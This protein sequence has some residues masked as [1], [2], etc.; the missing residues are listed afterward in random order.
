MF[1]IDLHYIKALSEVEKF[2]PEHKQFLEK[3]YGNATFILSGRKEPRS[4]GVIIANCASREE[5]D[6]LICEDPF[7][8]EA[9]ARY[10][11]TEFLPSMTADNLQHLKAM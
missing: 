10:T 9:I 4:G 11:I 3:Y 7:H 8:R 2:I 5:V 1:I 6:A